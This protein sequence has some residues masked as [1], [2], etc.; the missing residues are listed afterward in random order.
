MSTILTPQEKPLGRKA[1]RQRLAV[2]KINELSAE[3][4]LLRA[5]LQTSEE[6]LRIKALE[7][8]EIQNDL[9]DQLSN[10]NGQ[11]A[12]LEKSLSDRNFEVDRLEYNVNF[13]KQEMAEVESEKERYRLANDQIAV[14]LKAIKVARAQNEIVEWRTASQKNPLR[15]C[16]Q[17]I[18]G[19][20]RKDEDDRFAAGSEL[21][22]LPPP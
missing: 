11:V 10:L 7:S 17:R 22:R 16:Y 12:N 9:S 13:L 20:F 1:L 5:K 4:A 6:A 19:W 15:R 3:I 18:E 21:L 14:E 8:I 2:Q